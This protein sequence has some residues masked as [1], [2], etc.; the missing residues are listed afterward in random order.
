MYI[1]NWLYKY[2]HRFFLDRF[3]DKVYIGKRIL[4]VFFWI[5]DC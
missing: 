5:E 3:L 2:F 1:D 4:W